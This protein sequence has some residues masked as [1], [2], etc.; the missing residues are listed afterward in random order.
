MGFFLSVWEGILEGHAVCLVVFAFKSVVRGESSESF[1]GYK[2][3]RA[4][5]SPLTP[6]RAKGYR[7]LQPLLSEGGRNSSPH[8]P[9]Y[10][11]PLQVVGAGKEGLG[12]RWSTDNLPGGYQYVRLLSIEILSRLTVFFASLRLCV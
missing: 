9:P 7:P 6:L 2:G 1:T 10:P 3:E 5:P 12:A 8:T 4:P 11:P